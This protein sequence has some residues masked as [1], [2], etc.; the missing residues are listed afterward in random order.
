MQSS[1]EETLKAQLERLHGSSRNA[2][3]EEWVRLFKVPAPRKSSREFLLKAV[4]HRLQ[5]DFYGDLKPST[6]KMLLKIAERL[7]SGG[8]ITDLIAR[9]PAAKPGTRLIRTWR[10]ETHEVL[11]LDGGA[12]E[13]RGEPYRSLSTIATKLT[14][15]RRN[16]P[17]FFG[18][19]ETGA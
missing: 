4:G 17:A 5:A 16:G 12:F 14:G 18:L 13:W 7:R 9:A 8:S 2:L 3:A 11:V 6:R 15:T 19:R 10:G 1:H